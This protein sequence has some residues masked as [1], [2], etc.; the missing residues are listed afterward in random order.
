M[1]WLDGDVAPAAAL[2]WLVNPPEDR[3][4]PDALTQL[5][6]ISALR[7]CGALEAESKWGVAPRSLA[8][9]YPYIPF[10]FSWRVLNRLAHVERGGET[11]RPAR[12]VCSGSRRLAP[13]L[14]SSAKKKNETP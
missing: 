3:V 6:L 8:V 10:T 4:A 14:G 1:L 5:A 7:K 9:K 11:N 13:A 2:E 12:D